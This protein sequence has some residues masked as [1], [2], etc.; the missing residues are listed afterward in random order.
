MTVRALELADA[1]ACDAIVESLPYHFGNAEGRAHCA[2]AV[3]AERGLVAVDSDRVLGFVTWVPRFDAAAEVT[4][5]AV[6]ADQRRRGVGRMLLDELVGRLRSD[7]KRLLVVL[8]VSP[9]GD[10]DGPADGY[11]ATRAFYSA[12][13][14]VLA[15]ELPREWDDDRAV[16]MVRPL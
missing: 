14:F 4:W 6:R 9:N 10:E 7:G 3:R 12:M 13:G 5:M 15:R 2:A 11:A 1:P 16:M 8:T